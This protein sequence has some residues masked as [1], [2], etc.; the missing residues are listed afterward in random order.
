[1]SKVKTLKPTFDKKLNCWVATHKF[2]SYD[3]PTTVNVTFAANTKTLIDSKEIE[4]AEKTNIEESKKGVEERE[5]LIAEWN[6]DVELPNKE[7]WDK[8]DSVLEIDNETDELE[9][10][11]NQLLPNTEANE[12]ENIDSIHS[13]VEA[14]IATY[15]ESKEAQTQYYNNILDGFLTNL[16]EPLQKTDN[17]FSFS[18]PTYGGVTNVEHEKLSSVNEKE[19]LDK[20]YEKYPRTDGSILY[21]YCND[22]I[23]IFIDSKTLYRTTIRIVTDAKALAMN[24]KAADKASPFCVAELESAIHDL[25]SVFDSAKDGDSA[26]E[27]IIKYLSSLISAYKSVFDAVD[28]TY[29]KN[30]KQIKKTVQ[31][32][33]DKAVKDLQKQNS[34][35]F[36]EKKTI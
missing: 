28:C 22:S 14:D 24:G 9:K 25:K 35:F 17:N 34:K 13:E 5:Q 8:L 4:D 11:I 1:M 6:K 26:S 12:C 15:E 31:D 32:C 10:L 18:Y 16:N 30:L 36:Q 33:Y 3:L 20:G 2:G 27:I 29:Q 7:L 21:L 23:K 19:L